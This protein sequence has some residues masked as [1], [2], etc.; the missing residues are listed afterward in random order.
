MFGQ[1]EELLRDPIAVVPR[2]LVLVIA[3]TIHEFA[4]AWSA[5]RFGDSTPRDN[6]RVTLNPLSHLD[7][8]GSLVFLLSG[9]G[10]AKP[11]PVNI[12]ALERSSRLAPMWV[13]VA[14]PISN[15]IMAILGAIPIRL[16][17]MQGLPPLVIEFFLQF[18]WLNL[19][20]M[21]FNLIP[22]FPLDGEKVLTYLLPPESGLRKVM[23]Q[24]RPIGPMIL[25]FL[26]ISPNLLGFN[27][28]GTLIGEPSS[29]MF[30]ILAGLG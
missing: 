3:L 11:V 6:G 1:I 15:L 13:A 25:L 30:E 4:H 17:L 29:T 12:Y 28:L 2:L 24:V 5:D 19:I 18:V 7:P 8:I 23:D 16:G 20:L 26:I 10:W 14:G 21:F 22:I 9:F 27:L